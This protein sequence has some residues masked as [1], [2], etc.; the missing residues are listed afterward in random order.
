MKLSH[1]NLKR[2]LK[3]KI[4]VSNPLKLTQVLN[5][6]RD[7]FYFLILYSLLN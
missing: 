2:V 6:N 3:L 5:I 1:S 7:S 4:Q